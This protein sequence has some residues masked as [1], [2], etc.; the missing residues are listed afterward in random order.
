MNDT[1]AL[2]ITSDNLPAKCFSIIRKYNP[3]SIGEIKKRAISNLPILEYNAID[4]DGLNSLLKCYS[5]LSTLGVS[6]AF[7]DGG[8]LSSLELMYNLQKSYAATEAEV[9]LL[10]DEESE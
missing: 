9:S 7:L 4:H 1:L 3:I 6:V 8:E 2:I 10:I 5:E